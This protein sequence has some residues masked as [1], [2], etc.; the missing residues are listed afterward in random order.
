MSDSRIRHI[1]ALTE[2]DAEGVSV[3]QLLRR[4][5]YR[6]PFYGKLS[7]TDSLYTELIRNYESGVRGIDLA[8]DI[9]HGGGE[10]QGW[11]R[12]LRL[13]DDGDA[14]WG[15][16]EWTPAGRERVLN[17]LYR[18]MSVEFAT[19]YEDDHGELHGATLFGAALT[20]RPFLKGMEPVELTEPDEPEEEDHDMAEMITIAQALGLADDA[21][22]ASILEAIAAL[23]Q[24]RQD[25]Q[26]AASP[27]AALNE[28]R[29]Q[30][31]AL[32]EQNR[33]LTDRVARLETSRRNAEISRLME[34]GRLTPAMLDA[35]SGHLRQFAERD[36]DG[37]VAFV[38]AL[39]VSVSM[40]ETGSSGGNGNGAL[41][42]F[43]A[44]VD[45]ARTDGRTYSEAVRLIARTKPELVEAYREAATNR[46]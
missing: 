5:E 32:S 21:D 43:N 27:D 37:F 7:V 9:D 34:I 30:N 33:A 15:D 4:G 12:G 17:R 19:D 35:A 23:T 14:L 44:A 10:A 31:V 18:Y 6:H 2:P 13:S 42:M 26:T 45:A 40:S 16:I 41:A 1:I 24:A 28:A 22:E 11:F 29:S 36:L 46:V 20:N 8:V 25:A 39:P 3:V 38:E